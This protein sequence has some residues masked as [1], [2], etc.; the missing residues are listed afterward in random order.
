MDNEGKTKRKQKSRLIVE[1]SIIEGAEESEQT[2]IKIDRFTGGVIEGA[3]V[4]SKP[5]WH[6]NEEVEMCIKIEKAKRMGDWINFT[7][8]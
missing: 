3:L 4:K 2:R 7:C 1:E 5:V 6:K 8:T